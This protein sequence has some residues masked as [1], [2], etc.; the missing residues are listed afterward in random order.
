MG[1]PDMEVTAPKEGFLYNGDTIAELS[2]ASID[3]Q[4]ILFKTRWAS[5]SQTNIL[6]Y[7]RAWKQRLPDFLN[8]PRCLSMSD[9]STRSSSTSQQPDLSLRTIMSHQP[10]PRVRSVLLLHI[11]Y[12][13]IAALSTRAALLHAVA[14]S[15]NPPVPV[16]P[17][18]KE[19]STE[20][21]EACVYHAAQIAAL[22]TLLHDFSLLQGESALDIFY[23][24][25]AGMLLILRLLQQPTEA[26]RSRL[27]RERQIKIFV[28]RTTDKLRN[29]IRSTSKSSTMARFASVLESFASLPTIGEDSSTITHTNDPGHSNVPQNSIPTNGAAAVAGTDV[30]DGLSNNFTAAGFDA[31]T[32]D[33]TPLSA[34][35]LHDLTAYT[36]QNQNTL[37]E[38]P[39]LPTDFS[40]SAFGNDLDLGWADFEGLLNGNGLFAPTTE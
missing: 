38:L 34:G 25:S 39:H 7:L 31:T 17:G 11:Q 36:L 18:F 13:Y 40:W 20:T 29:D 21:A 26:A 23:G 5:V 22:I 8:I 3:L 27:E 30:L 12:H 24:Y 19:T 15:H 2:A 33:A 14:S 37:E 4:K 32:H 10:P 9:V 35:N 16:S 28:R 6:E 1:D